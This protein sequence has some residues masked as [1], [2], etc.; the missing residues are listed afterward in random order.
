MLRASLY[1]PFFGKKIHSFHF[2]GAVGFLGGLT[3]GIGMAIALDLN[4]RIVLLMT[5]IGAATFF[6]LVY[7]AKGLTGKEVIVYYH[8][9]ISI[10]LFCT[11][12]LFVLKLPILS[13]LDIT[14]L[15]IGVFLG[16]GRIGCYSVG[17]CHGRPY[18]HGVRY[19]QKHVEAGFTWYY[20]NIPLLPVQLIESIYV[21]GIVITGTILL[22]NHVAPGTVLICY[23]V[24]YGFMR[25]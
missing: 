4:P 14:L 5:A 15:G 21:F 25:S 9:E 1:I 23:T 18:K 8:H 10:L 6:L 16:F 7:L 20:K 13:Y 22:L 12:A 17:C 3:L 24:V 11:L 19:G 2:F